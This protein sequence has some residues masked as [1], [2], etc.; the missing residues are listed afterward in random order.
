[1]L[2]L[3]CSIFSFLA[4]F[5]CC[6][7]SPDSIIRIWTSSDYHVWLWAGILWWV[8]PFLKLV[9]AKAQKID[10]K[11]NEKQSRKQTS[12]SSVSCRSCYG[13]GLDFSTKLMVTKIDSSAV[14]GLSPKCHTPLNSSCLSLMLSGNRSVYVHI[15]KEN[16][17]TMFTQPG[18][19]PSAC[20]NTH[21]LSETLFWINMKKKMKKKYG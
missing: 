4:Q 11:F 18:D 7:I 5:S 14:F 20:M 12:R 10:L 1:M 9:T 16:I 2:V 17:T 19:P 21:I 15:E 6:E 3:K 13:C 8:G